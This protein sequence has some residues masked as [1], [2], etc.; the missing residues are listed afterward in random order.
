MGSR[1]DKSTDLSE[2]AILMDYVPEAQSQLIKE[3]FDEVKGY[4]LGKFLIAW[5]GHANWSE[6]DHKRMFEKYDQLSPSEK[7]YA[8]KQCG[9][10]PP[11]DYSI[12]IN[13]NNKK[14]VF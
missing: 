13:N 2:K 6:D 10:C 12:I 3:Y 8:D 7:A 5:E 1:V 14:R 4:R 9:G 11:R